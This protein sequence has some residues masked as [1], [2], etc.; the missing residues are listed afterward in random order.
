MQNYLVIIDGCNIYAF[1][2]EWMNWSLFFVYLFIYIFLFIYFNLFLRV[3]KKCS[4]NSDLICEHLKYLSGRTALCRSP[5][6]LT[7]FRLACKRR[8]R[9][10]K[11]PKL[12]ILQRR[13]NLQLSAHKWRIH[14]HEGNQSRGW[15]SIIRFANVTRVLVFFFSASVYIWRLGSF[16]SRRADCSSYEE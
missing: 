4:A 2:H 5:L 13:S 1:I 15:I 11:R 8:S 14:Y 6:P 3:L 10:L 12:Y 7:N 16:Q 9:K